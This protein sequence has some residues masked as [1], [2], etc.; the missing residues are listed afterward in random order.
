VIAI[1]SR[2]AVLAITSGGEA[3]TPRMIEDVGFIRPSERRRVA[4]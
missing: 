4:V 1:V 2:V 3:I